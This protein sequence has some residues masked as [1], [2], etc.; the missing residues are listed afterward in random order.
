[1][2]E[3]QIFQVVH[4]HEDQYSLWPADRRPPLG[5]FSE[6]TTGS[7][8]ECLARVREVWTDMRPRSVR[9]AQK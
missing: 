5:W 3:A 1:M 9:E 8:E 6:G 7:R 2:P 4:N